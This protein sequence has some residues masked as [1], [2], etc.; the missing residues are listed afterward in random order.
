V[1]AVASVERQGTAAVV[2][3]EGDI[4]YAEAPALYGKL[5]TVC[6]RRDVRKIVVDF[7]RAGRVDSS[8]VA[9][10]SLLGR[11]LAHAGKTLEL[12]ALAEHHQAALALAPHD[13]TPA[14]R[15]VPP[16]VL[17]RIGGN[18]IDTGS[19][20]R[21]LLGLVGETVRQSLAVLTGRRR[22]PSGSISLQIAKMGVDAIFIV[23]LLSF[24]IGMTMAFQGAVQLQRFGASVFVA[25]MIGLSVVRELAPLMTAIVLTG[26]TGAAIAAE[27]GTMRVRSEI[28]ALSTM[29][30]HPV[31]FLVVPR[32]A[33]IT[34]VTPALTLM[35]I[36]I[37][38]AGGMAVASYALDMSIVNFW[39][40][41]SERVM[42]HDILH[43]LAKSVVFAWIIGFSGAH[44]GMRAHGDASSVGAATTRTVVASIFFI[45]LVDA[46]FATISTAVK[47]Q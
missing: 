36:F 44:L 15:V 29:G 40:R 32:L 18:V 3:L 23:G 30:V 16:G 6:K 21:A 19:S 4:S 46:V 41:V 11:Q 43:G 9:V 1:S 38:I 35:S 2:H 47:Y 27:L 26:R 10:L 7:S 37:G 12:D 8:G 24:L 42:M 39:Q 20:T 33:A 22:L 17:E 28:D 31:R 5:R 13:V 14:A 25:D 34:F 45:I